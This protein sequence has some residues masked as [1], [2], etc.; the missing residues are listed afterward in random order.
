MR[1]MKFMFH[2]GK[3][4]RIGE[5]QIWSKNEWNG[6]PRIKKHAEG[7]FTEPDFRSGF[8]M[9]LALARHSVAM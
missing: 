9:F 4:C 6:E 5:K 3:C 1:I 8:A 2:G 7:K